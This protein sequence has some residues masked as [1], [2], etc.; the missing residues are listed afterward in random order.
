MKDKIFFYLN[1]LGK[2]F[3]I[4]KATLLLMAFLIYLLFE[5]ATNKIISNILIDPIFKNLEQTERS[6]IIYIFISLLTCI[7]FFVYP[8]RKNYQTNKTFNL[9][10]TLIALIYIYNR[11]F[12]HTWYFYP[13]H[14]SF[15]IY[16]SDFITLLFLLNTILYI[17]YFLHITSYNYLK[18][19]KPEIV[20][21]YSS[22]VLD[23]P[24]QKGDDD[25]LARKNAAKKLSQEILKIQTEESFGIG[26]IGDWGSGKS[27]FISM[28]KEEIHEVNNVIAIDFHP[29][30]STS[31]DLIITDF[32][33]LLK[34]N[35]TPYSG[36]VGNELDKYSSKLISYNENF[37]GKIYSD[38]FHSNEDLHSQFIII[39]EIIKNFNKKIII[40]IDDLD[41]LDKKE[42]VETIKLIRNTAKF[43]NTIF[44]A[45]Y[46]RN[47]VINAISD[48][49]DHNKDFYLEKI[50][51]I[52]IP[53]PAPKDNLV[54]ETL[55][56][57]LIEKSPQ[58][59][60][61]I[62]KSFTTDTNQFA[63]LPDENKKALKNNNAIEFTEEFIK[64]LRDVKR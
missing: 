52:E 44:L 39:N 18:F 4:K 59:Q 5:N 14:Y 60:K 49:N 63:F 45:A 38:L 8:F 20:K 7:L 41:R 22:F 2:H 53:L 30:K 11:F 40:I 33:S 51:Q 64:N 3:S 9:T 12:G 16:Y 21:N 31:P 55:K 47:Y 61:E 27:S 50:F 25:I 15:P 43:S 19:I 13:I 37:L 56:K 6:T 36:Q 46:A 62:E 10:I 48:I 54:T 24:W 58:K 23:L 42:I 17:K 57:L 34:S 26:I 32:F 35:L 1:S 29:W 28:I